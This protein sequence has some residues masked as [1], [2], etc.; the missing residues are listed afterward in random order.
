MTRCK[1]L[2]FTNCE[3]GADDAFNEW[4]D[5][6]HGPEVVALTPAC[7]THRFRVS[8]YQMNDD[9]HAHRYLTIYEF[10][11]GPEAAY[12][13]LMKASFQMSETLADAKL[14]FYDELG[15]PIR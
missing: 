7:S 8:D 5:K 10:E 12:E 13:G 4:Y 9:D 15:D 2:V 11:C 1:A 6:V 14:V 3:E